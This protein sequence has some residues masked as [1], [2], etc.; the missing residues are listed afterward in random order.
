MLVDIM[1]WLSELNT[2]EEAFRTP[3]NINHNFVFMFTRQVATVH[4][5]P[6]FDFTN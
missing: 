3:F 6:Q 5:V 2:G 4:D 1:I